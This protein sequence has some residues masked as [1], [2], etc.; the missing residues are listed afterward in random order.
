MNSVSGPDP[1]G[2][3]S[4]FLTGTLSS[5]GG[6]STCP[7]EEAPDGPAGR[8]VAYFDELLFIPV[9]EDTVRADG[10]ATGEYHWTS[11]AGSRVCR[12]VRRCW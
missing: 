10:I 4:T 7:G 5:S 6:K 8:R 9:P 12:G 2:L 1:S 11:T 3:S